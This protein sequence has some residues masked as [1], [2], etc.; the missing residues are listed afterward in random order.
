MLYKR[1][2]ELVNKTNINQLTEYLCIDISKLREYLCG[3]VIIPCI[4]QKKI[5]DFFGID[6][7]VYA[8]RSSIPDMVER[9]HT[10][11]AKNAIKLADDISRYI[12]FY[13][14]AVSNGNELEKEWI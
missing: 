1:L 7:L 12:L 9:V 6:Y 2:D 4:Y 13:R 10:Q 5:I 8:P 3:D 11:E 14:K